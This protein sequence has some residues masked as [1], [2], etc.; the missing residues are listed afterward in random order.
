MLL[1]SA[2]DVPPPN[3]NVTKRGSTF[4]RVEWDEIEIDK[5]HGIISK[6]HI[7]VTSKHDSKI[8][9]RHV[10]GGSQ[11]YFMAMDLKPYTSYTF[12]VAAVT[13][14]S[15]PYSDARTEWTLEDSPSEVLNVRVLGRTQSSITLTWNEPLVKN[16]LIMKYKVEY[17]VKNNTRKNFSQETSDRT[18]S[19]TVTRLKP[20][21]T[22]DM[23]V[24][25]YNSIPGAPSDDIEVQTDE[26]LP[27]EPTSVSVV[28]GQY[29]AGLSWQEPDTKN[30]RLVGYTVR[31]K[32]LQ[33]TLSNYPRDESTYLGVPQTKQHKFTT[34]Q[35][36]MRY[37]FTVVA[38][39]SRGSGSESFRIDI[40]QPAGLSSLVACLLACMLH[41]I[42]LSG[43]H[44]CLILFFPS[45]L[46]LASVHQHFKSES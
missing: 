27:S 7:T 17:H 43:V 35:P 22:Y 33:E 29:H 15:G 32:A 40:T 6:Y 30:G 19:L 25:A 3:V 36:N 28:V 38:H 18:T 11:R 23:V 10:V 8:H 24:I 34:L 42:L 2:P 13:N 12:R 26:G 1:S 45:Y 14:G 31:F 39:T 5:Q 9:H 16:G 41:H 4:L 20:Y 37:N 46:R 44:S 21:T